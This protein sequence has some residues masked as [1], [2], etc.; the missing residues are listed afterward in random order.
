[1]SI[2]EVNQ[3]FADSFK[4]DKPEGAL[5]SAVEPGSPAE[6]AGL[7]S[8]D[9]IRKVDGQPVVASGDLP[10]L[11]GLS[12]PGAKVTLE[13]WR[14]GR[15][16]SVAATLG[17][18]K[19]AGTQVAKGETE[20]PKGKLGLSLR[21]MQPQEQQAAGAAGGLVIEQVA[22]PA[23]RAGVQRGDV[24]IAVNDTPA[25]N[26]DQVR[27]AVGKSGKT[28]ALLIQRGANRIFVPVELG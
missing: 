12:T 25:R 16:E 18:P 11:I 21:P 17:G 5:I 27:E 4:L 7:K 10:A 1:M 22:G 3:A 15:T 14:Q 28:V 2:Q 6:Q 9:V 24:L 20:P 13:V 19:D 26:I 8:G 23:A